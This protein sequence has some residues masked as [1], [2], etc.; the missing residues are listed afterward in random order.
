MHN[1]YFK[2]EAEFLTTLRYGLIKIQ[3]APEQV[4]N[5]MKKWVN[6]YNSVKSSI[7]KKNERWNYVKVLVA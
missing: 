7:Q 5:V 3:D 4:L 6:I 2:N 1:R